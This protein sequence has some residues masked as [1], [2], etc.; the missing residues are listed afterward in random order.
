MPTAMFGTLE[1]CPRAMARLWETIRRE[2]EAKGLKEGHGKY[3]TVA[4]RKFYK[5]YHTLPNRIYALP[6]HSRTHR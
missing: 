1:K 3:R 4:Q 6:R 5:R 2:L